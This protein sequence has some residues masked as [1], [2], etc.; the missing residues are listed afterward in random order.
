MRVAVT[1]TDSTS[2]AALAA[3]ASAD[4]AK[5]I[6]LMPQNSAAADLLCISFPPW[7]FHCAAWRRL[8]APASR[9]RADGCIVV[10]RYMCDPIGMYPNLSWRHSAQMSMRHSMNSNCVTMHLF[11][12]KLYWG[13]AP[14]ASALGST[15]P[16]EGLAGSGEERRS[17]GG[18]A[19]STVPLDGAGRDMIGQDLRP[20]DCV[21]CERGSCPCVRASIAA[22]TL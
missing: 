5:A 16:V 19:V 17:A 9:A 15:V 10:Y 13:A 8:F 2:P 6:E 1:T 20:A 11:V 3:W 4:V 22:A 18:S 14:C 21:S 12:S 7:D